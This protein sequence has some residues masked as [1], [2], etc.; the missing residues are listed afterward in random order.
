MKPFPPQLFFAALLL[1]CMALAL[2][3]AWLDGARCGG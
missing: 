2:G 3:M 1:L